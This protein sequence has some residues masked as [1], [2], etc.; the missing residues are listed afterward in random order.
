MQKKSSSTVK[1]Y[2][3][4]YR[5]YELIQY[6]EQRVGLLAQRIPL[7]LVM[8]FGSYAEGR[9]TAASDIDLL[10]VYEGRK[11]DDIYKIV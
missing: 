4:R 5:R 10:V 8:L 7:K 11:R 2:Y 9:Y 3:P 6:L 1:V